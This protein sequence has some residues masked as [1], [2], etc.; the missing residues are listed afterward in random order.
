MS[1]AEGTYTHAFL[2]PVMTSIETLEMQIAELKTA[3]LPDSEYVQRLAALM[4]SAC[5]IDRYWILLIDKGVEVLSEDDADLTDFQ[6]VAASDFNFDKTLEWAIQ[7]QCVTS[8]R[9]NATP[10]ITA[11]PYQR[12]RFFRAGEMPRRSRPHHLP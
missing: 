6:T 8:I 7:G 5:N 12:A 4:A 1:Y 9:I 10:T 3:D 2:T 11:F